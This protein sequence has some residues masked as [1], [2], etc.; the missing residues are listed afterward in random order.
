M[1]KRPGVH[2]DRGVEC[3]CGPYVYLCTVI[4]SSG[5]TL[6]PWLRALRPRQFNLSRSRFTKASGLYPEG[7]RA[8]VLN[9]KP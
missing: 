8:R 1:T 9:L 4:M 7:L 5:M 3:M 2:H 6:P